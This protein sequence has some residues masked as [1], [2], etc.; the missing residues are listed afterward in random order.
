[1]LRAHRHEAAEYVRRIADLYGSLDRSAVPY[2]LPEVLEVH[3]D[4]EVSW[5]IERRLAGRPFDELLRGLEG[6]D[7][8]RALRAY[9]DG[10]AAFR[11]LGRPSGWQGGCGELFTDERL[12]AERW[13][14][15]LAA[16]L[17]LQ[18]EQARPILAS[19][20]DD[21][22]GRVA[23]ILASARAEEAV[24]V[25][26]VHG[27]WFPGNVLLGDDLTVSAAI[28]LGWLTE[29]GAPDHDILSAAVF[30]EVRPTHRT[31][32]AVVLEAAVAR[33]IGAGARDALRRVRR[34]EQL[35]FAFVTEDEHLHQWC[36]AGLRAG[37][38]VRG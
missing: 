13:G 36:L 33:H 31:D 7:R 37:G 19:V 20:I 4:G 18:L 27:D 29:V 17:A 24:A 14:D 22:D 9:V 23:P 21:L 10:A 3:G 12:R 34:Y 11:A 1:V 2:A 16:R 30:C 38:P 15:L 28:D 26:L 5:S 6:D 25:T 8:A 35:R 32:D